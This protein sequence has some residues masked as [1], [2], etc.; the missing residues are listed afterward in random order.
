MF[1][2][3]ANLCT[4]HQRCFPP[5]SLSIVRRSLWL[6][7]QHLD[8]ETMNNNAIKNFKIRVLCEHRELEGLPGAELKII[9]SSSS[10]FQQCVN[11][12]NWKEQQPCQSR[13][14]FASM[15]SWLRFVFHVQHRM[16]ESPIPLSL[17]FPQMR[18]A[19]LQENRKSSDIGGHDGTSRDIRR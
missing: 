6:E 12:L 4:Y 19:L 2:P 1:T 13:Q 16:T 14:T 5:T 18:Q 3:R 7:Q 10:Q 15:K 17:V 8:K 11:I 9:I